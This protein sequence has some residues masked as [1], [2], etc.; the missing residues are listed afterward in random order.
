[1]SQIESVTAQQCGTPKGAD[2]ALLLLAHQ[3]EE[4]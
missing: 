1:V 3:P 2:L 4:Q